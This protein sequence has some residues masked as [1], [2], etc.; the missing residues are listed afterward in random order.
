MKCSDWV[1]S[2][3]QQYDEDADC[4]VLKANIKLVMR[5]DNGEIIVRR[6]EYK[7]KQMPK[8]Q[9]VGVNQG[10]TGSETGFGRW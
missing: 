5:R 1:K 7:S 3:K 2:R 10:S 4:E 6:P 9:I 8:I